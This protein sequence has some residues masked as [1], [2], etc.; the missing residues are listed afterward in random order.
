MRDPL[1]YNRSTVTALAI[2][3]AVSA[4]PVA[5]QSPGAHAANPSRPQQAAPHAAEEQAAHDNDVILLNPDLLDPKRARAPRTP[6]RLPDGSGE[7]YVVEVMPEVPATP[8]VAPNVL[9]LL[10]HPDDEIAFAPVL[11]RIARNGGSVTVVFATSGETEPGISG[12]K[13][14]E[15][16]AELREEEGR[17]A[18]FALRAQEPI[19]WQMRDGELANLAREDESAANEIAR[20]ANDLIAI[21]Q[22]DVVMTWGPDGGYGHS[23]HRMIS[24]LA[25]QVI[26]AMGENRPDLLYLAFPSNA[27]PAPSEFGGWIRINPEL[28][29]DEIRYEI[30]DLDASRVAIDCYQSQFDERARA[31]LPQTLHREIWQGKVHF[32]AAFPTDNPMR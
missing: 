27:G 29:S 6:P 5:A 2:Y 21:T 26:G 31:V 1:P 16:L 23:D 15:E 10:A 20:R 7:P 11:S 32:R 4:V 8:I 24:A 9:V 28:I 14:G 30:D 18:A 25:T 19:Y 22:P 13:P 12:L 3:L 17:C